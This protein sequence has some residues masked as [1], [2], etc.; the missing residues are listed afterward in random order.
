MSSLSWL[1]VSLVPV[2]RAL[3]MLSFLCGVG[4]DTSALT[5]GFDL[6]QLANLV[7]SR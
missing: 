5:I 3:R 7:G 4:N 1:F 6:S 2:V